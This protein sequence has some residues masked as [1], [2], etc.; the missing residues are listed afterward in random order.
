MISSPIDP[1]FS[2]ARRKLI[3][4]SSHVEAL[5]DGKSLALYEGVYSANDMLDLKL[6]LDG[7][8]LTNMCKSL[9]TAHRRKTIFPAIFPEPSLMQ[10]II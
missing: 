8:V 7:N 3:S 4:K 6:R 2:I 1:L 9:L 10:K 5:T